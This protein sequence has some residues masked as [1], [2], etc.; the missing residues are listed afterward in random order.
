[1]V[2]DP[3]AAEVVVSAGAPVVVLA[4][5]APVVVVSPASSAQA[6]TT[7]TKTV[8]RPTIFDRFMFLLHLGR[9]PSVWFVV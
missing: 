2:V 5:P 9:R 8:R 4:S 1:V 7:K 3:A 6:D